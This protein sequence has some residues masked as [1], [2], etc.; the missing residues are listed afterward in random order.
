MSIELYEHNV[1]PFEQISQA[2]ANGE[3]QI[4]VTATGTGKSYVAG[5]LIEDNGNKK[6]L[7]VTPRRN[8]SGQWGKLLENHLDRIDIF[9]YQKLA[10]VKPSNYKKTFLPY[11]LVV[12]DEVHH[13]GA[14]AWGKS[15]KYC[16]ENAKKL[17][18][19]VIG[20][21]ADPVRYSDGGYD[22]S[23]EMFD[24][25]R[26]DGIAL[27][28]AISQGI[29]PQFNYVSD[30][31]DLPDDIKRAKKQVS[32]DKSV[33][34]RTLLSKLL[35]RLNIGND[36]MKRIVSIVKEN[37]ETSKTPLSKRHVLL[38]ISSLDDF[39]SAKRLAKALGYENIFEMSCKLSKKKNDAA[40]EA[41]QTSKNGLLICV[42]MFNEG[43]HCKE[44]DTII[45][46][47]R[48]SS[49]NIFFQQLGRALDS[50]SNKDIWVFDLVANA[51]VLNVNSISYNGTDKFSP[52]SEIIRACCQQSIVKDYTVDCLK[53]IGEIRRLLS[54]RA[55]WTEEEDDI[56]RQFYPIEGCHCFSR[57]SE[58]SESA[59]K[60]RCKFL[61]LTYVAWTPE[62]LEILK[63]YYYDEGLA[64]VK[65]LNNKNESKVA[66]M[67]HKLGLK[68]KPKTVIWSKDDEALMRKYYADEGTAIAERLSV[69]YKAHQIKTK[70]SEMGL[71]FDRKEWTK[72]EL[73]II[74]KYYPNEAEITKQLPN[75]TWC[76]VKRQARIIGICK[77][78]PEVW[79][80]E[81]TD[82]LR[83]HSTT[84][85]AIQIATA[86]NKS[87]SSIR[88]YRKKYNI[89]SSR[90]SYWTPERDAVF[91]ELYPTATRK[92]LEDAFPDKSWDSIVARASRTGIRRMK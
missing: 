16:L 66:N 78:A 76:A 25:N 10:R 24:G 30:L 38:F 26:T 43:V 17:H 46:L 65:R 32:E 28:D 19:S 3:N 60:N 61:G 81:D 71:I 74:R 85:T 90:K 51:K 11:D 27:E 1:M 64:V 80:D 40:K 22:V 47:R 9:T 87:V 91:R 59:C 42:D 35:G 72:V 34:H 54:D 33:K 62:E 53:I 12:V 79:T 36:N 69:K 23:E 68:R 67:A 37:I 49:P 6:V 63:T 50:G 48:T 44:V 55:L 5:K 70:A 89:E 20:L 84:M 73:D 45:M 83:K 4:F 77:K 15:I 88:K 21:T 52:V 58:R 39:A 92:E 86:L 18:L 57:L 2:I 8:I 14:S 13:A 29:L 7:I 41:F 31:F 75:R 56:L 82:F